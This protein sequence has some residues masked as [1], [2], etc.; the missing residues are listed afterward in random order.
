MKDPRSHLGGVNIEWG[1][2]PEYQLFNIKEDPGQ[3]TN[4]AKTNK[5]KLEEMK[6]RFQQLHKEKN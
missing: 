2:S 3:Q 6:E 1:R 5:K 4:L